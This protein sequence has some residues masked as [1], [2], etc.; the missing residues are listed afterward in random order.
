MNHIIRGNLM[1]YSFKK[2]HL[3]SLRRV[4]VGASCVLMGYCPGVFAQNADL[5]TVEEV[6][7]TGFKG[8]VAAA[9]VQKR[10]ESGLVDVIKAE[11]VAKFPDSNLA[12]SL[13]RLPGVAVA[14]DGGEG[15]SISVRGLGPEYTRVRI[16]GLEAQ[17]ASN[18]FEGINRARGFDFNVF[19]SEL[20]NSLTVRKSPSAEVEEG[21]LGATV[22]LQTARPFDSIGPQFAFSAKAAY[23]DL[24]ENTDPRIALVA[25]N[26][27]LDDTVGVLVS[28]AY[29]ESRRISQASHNLNWDRM[30]ENGGWCDP[31]NPDGVC[32]EELPEGITY[33]QLRSSAIY[34]PRIPRLGEFDLENDRLG[35]TTSWQ[36]QPSDATEV[37]LDILY[38]DHDGYRKESLLTPI[39]LF[40]AQSQ[41][42][43]PEAIIR[44]AEVRGNDLIYAKI[45]NVD[46]RAETSIFDYNTEF[47]QTGLS[48]KHEFSDRLRLEFQVGSSTSSFDEPTEST[49]QVDRLNTDGF[50]YDFRDSMKLPKIVWGFDT[51]D[52]ANYYFGPAQPGFTGGA[53]GPEIRLR[54]QAVENSFEQTGFK[55]A[56][57]INAQWTLKT[58]LSLRQY[59][60]ESDAQRLTNER[61]IPELP[62]GITVAD[63]VEPFSGFEGFGVPAETATSW[64]VPSEAAFVDIFD[65]YSNRGTFELRRDIASARSNIYSVDEDDLAAFVQGDFDLELF[66]KPA[67]G[68]IGLRYVRTE[69]NAAGFAEA[70][71]NTE[72]LS[73]S[74]SY[75]N[76]LPSFNLVVEATDDLD[77]RVSGSRVMTR[78]PLSQLTPGGAVSVTGGT[79]LVSQGNPNLDPIE[80]NAFDVSA[81]WYFA[82]DSLVSL[83]FFYK[84]VKTYI[85]TLRTTVPY[86]TLGFPDAALDGTG[87]LPTDDFVYSRPVNSDGGPLEGFELNLQMPL[88]FLSGA[89]ENFGILA[90]YT[91]VSSD[92]TYVVN[93]ALEP[94][95]PGRTAVL[96]LL[97]LSE[98]TANA[99]LYYEKG[100]FEGRIS[101]SYR[102]DYLRNVPGINGQDADGTSGSTFVDASISYA[103]GDNYQISLEGQNLTDTYEHLYNDTQAK[104]NE[105]YRSS[106]RQYVLGVRY[107]F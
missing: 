19:A 66:G 16:N 26:T 101:T 52:P 22:D 97:S 35:I 18:G 100:A 99:T 50:I 77:I 12:E 4:S 71:V 36:W 45:D 28:V 53:T 25:S 43:K 32:F 79:K 31:Q 40:R 68:D 91:R 38:S 102:D 81:E 5:K 29:S 90:N 87:V 93:P 37:T 8:S 107:T 74:R 78:P 49:L 23:N 14:R 75:N 58:G 20:F 34:H 96:P 65:I 6:T 80:A 21:S 64:V 84:D 67:R 1:K 63:L 17:A 54:P 13:Q 59:S 69:Q 7:V 105:Y 98:E 41:Q 88:T 73:E 82:D 55:L 76:V 95:D 56:F 86:N 94:G 42:G 3:N 39:G 27:F 9:L 85:A 61:D 103:L 48:V 30:T 106:G 62:A 33:D 89:L 11:D 47:L 70:G 57:D 15:R 83:S 72:L 24:S 2:A 44:E 60:F 51:D 10:N 92:I 104:R 46:L